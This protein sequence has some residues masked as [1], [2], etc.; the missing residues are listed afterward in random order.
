MILQVAKRIANARFD[1]NFDMNKEV[2]CR[3]VKSNQQGAF[4]CCF[5]SKHSTFYRRNSINRRK[6]LYKFI[7]NS[8]YDCKCQNTEIRAVNGNNEKRGAKT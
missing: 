7:K 8:Y 3:I 4:C 6:M 5:F 2:P 1:R